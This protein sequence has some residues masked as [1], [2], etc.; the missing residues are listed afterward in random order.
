MLNQWRGIEARA[1]DSHEGALV[2]AY[3]SLTERLAS[4]RSP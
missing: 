3:E 1:C 2:L 4:S